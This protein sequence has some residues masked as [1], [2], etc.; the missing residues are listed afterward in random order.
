MKPEISLITIWT[1][2]IEEMKVFYNEIRGFPIINDL[3]EYA[4]EAENRSVCRSRR[5]YS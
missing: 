2:N 3:G 1:E 4:L 5:E